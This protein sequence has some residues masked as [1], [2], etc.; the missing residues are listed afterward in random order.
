M[1]TTYTWRPNG[2]RYYSS[3][4]SSAAGDDHFYYSSNRAFR[5]DFNAPTVDKKTISIKSAILRVYIGTANS[6]TLTIGYNYST[7]FDNRKSLLA[8]ITGVSM[9]TKTGSKTIDITSIVQAYCRDG[10]TGKFYLWGYGTGGSSSNSNFRGFNPSSSYSSQRP[11]IT[12]TY[13]TSRARI[14]TNGEWK[15]AVPYVYENGIWQP[16]AIKFCNNGSWE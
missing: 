1:S 3:S 14:Y 5:M 11:Y 4:G 2:G 8:K 12:L 15:T 7:S 9:G 10:Q 13:D 16:A 6:A